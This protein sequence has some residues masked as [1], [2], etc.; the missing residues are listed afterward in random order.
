LPARVL[1]IGLDAADP[2]L[3][4]RWGNEGRLP[5]FSSFTMNADSFRLANSLQTLPGGLWAEL[6]TGRSCGHRGIF[7]PDRQLHTG[8]TEPRPID[9]N[10]VDPRAYWT[11]ASDA[12]QRVAVIDLP[13]TVPPKSLNGVFVAEWGTHDRVF[14]Q[15]SVPIDFFDEIRESYGT[16]PLWSR[17][18]PRRTTAA[19]DGHDG[20]PEQCHQLL[21][22][23]HKGIEQK[24]AL[25]LDVIG[26]EQW[27]LFACAFPEGQ[28]S[29]HQLWHF[30][31]GAPVL[32]E[33]L[34]DGIRSVYER[35]DSSLGVLIEAA[36]SEATVFVAATHGF[37]HP[38]GGRQ[39]IPE[40][41][42]RL[43]YGSGSR[44]SAQVRSRVPKRVRALA[45]RVVPR[46][47]REKL[48]ARA[49]SL[50]QPLES[51][52]TKAVALD[53]D[54][55]SWIR[56]NLKGREPYGAVEPGPEA[57]AMIEDLRAE[58]R[59]L[60]HPGS[61]QPIVSQI[62]TATEAFG[63]HHHPD[64]PDLI[65]DFRTDLGVLDSCRSGRVG[66]VRVPFEQT[67]L[68]TG[69]HP[70][71]PSYL[72]IGGSGSP[73]QSLAEEG[74]AVDLAATI[75]ARLGVAQPDWCEG[76]PLS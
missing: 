69:A 32:D 24:T 14:G 30:L 73:N 48:Q 58:L 13:H 61:G 38:T 20:T 74:S 1:F 18:W 70:A 76:R 27:D 63:E 31:D 17:P 6:N 72:W 16:Y 65:V 46:G 42:I 68:R 35:L 33:R 62:V 75:L 67:G 49:G 43:G 26:R 15:K 56:L 7:F 37:V 19:C 21:D 41:L 64:V 71:A 23:L 66:V 52:L 50:P 60:E 22:D 12:G 51:P 3:L 5:E 4:E 53:G 25:L 36:G 55:C 44:V 39:L 28:C 34:R 40:V 54:R 59:Q 29:G 47:P 2:S 11:A 10:E 8:E 9:P 45:R 57:D